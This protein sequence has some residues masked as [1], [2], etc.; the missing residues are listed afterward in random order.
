VIEQGHPYEFLKVLREKPHAIFHL[1]KYVY[2]A[3]SLLDERQYLSVS[4]SDFSEEW[5][6]R[7]ISSLRPDQELA[8][9]STITISGRTW[10]IPMI[11]FAVD[12][13]IAGEMLD[14]L[15]LFLP[16]AVALNLAIFTSGRSFHAYSTALLS[17]K[18]WI[19][20]MGRLLLVN[21]R[22]R[23]EIIDS[24]W[25][26]HRLIGGFCS[27]R[28]SNNSGLYLGAPSRIKLPS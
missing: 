2:K 18:E 9:H 10:H 24:R 25:I 7:E 13:A 15:R 6:N 22:D 4:A 14:R 1:S 19:G 27:L 8:I 17:P 26:G 16:R 12:G 3:D 5:V 20:F 23:K 28:W 21:P 11:D